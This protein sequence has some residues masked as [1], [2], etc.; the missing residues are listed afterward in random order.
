MRNFHDADGENPVHSPV[1]EIGVALNKLKN[2]IVSGE[3]KSNYISFRLALHT[4]WL[5]IVQ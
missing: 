4:N 2:V 3:I 1:V 5:V